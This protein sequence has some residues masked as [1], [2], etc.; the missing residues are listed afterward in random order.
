MIASND[1]TCY[2][3]EQPIPKGSNYSRSEK[4]PLHDACVGAHVLARA[5][6]K[7]NR[8]E[9]LITVGAPIRK[10]NGRWLHVV[11]QTPPLIKSARKTAEQVRMEESNAYWER[12]YQRCGRRG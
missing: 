9:L 4:R 12:E 6:Q 8:C 11:C 5:E 10:M 7:C 3:C 2:K 1:Y